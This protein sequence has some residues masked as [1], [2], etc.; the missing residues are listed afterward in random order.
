MGICREIFQKHSFWGQCAN[1]LIH[2]D[3]PAK[4]SSISTIN[5]LHQPREDASAGSFSD[6]RK[7][8]VHVAP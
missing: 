3:A 4:E 6:L 5:T 7:A 8:A 2:R 1:E